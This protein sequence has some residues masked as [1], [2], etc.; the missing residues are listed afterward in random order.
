MAPTMSPD[1]AADLE[2][3]LRLLGKHDEAA[4]VALTGQHPHYFDVH[5]F[6]PSNA[7]TK[8]DAIIINTHHVPPGYVKVQG[9]DIW[10]VPGSDYAKTGKTYVVEYRPDTVNGGMYWFCNCPVWKFRISK[11]ERCKHIQRVICVEAIEPC[12]ESH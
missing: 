8:A 9:A 1:S 4:A 10:E 5:T 3:A 6:C 2:A 11:G 7:C 12:M